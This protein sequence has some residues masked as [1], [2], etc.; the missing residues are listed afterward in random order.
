MYLYNST[1]SELRGTRP[2][3]DESIVTLLK[4]CTARVRGVKRFRNCLRPK[5]NIV[6]DPYRPCRTDVARA[7]FEKRESELFRRSSRRVHRKN[8]TFI[9]T[10]LN[11]RIVVSV[12][13]STRHYI[14]GITLTLGSLF[15]IGTVTRSRS[16]LT[17]SRRISYR[18]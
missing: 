17:E 16:Q 2:T 12:I 18:V 8:Y 13:R 11:A 15:L 5:Q 1:A 10:E 4:T 6:N 14:P 3:R 7:S 9:E